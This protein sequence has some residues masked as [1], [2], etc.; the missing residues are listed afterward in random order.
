VTEPADDKRASGLASAA[1]ALPLY[2]LA[3][4]ALL[5]PPALC[6]SLIGRGVGEGHPSWIAL[7]ALTASAW[8][9]GLFICFKH[10]RR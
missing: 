3:L 7:G 4:G 9:L 5:M 10:W 1:M 2:S 8:L 6:Y